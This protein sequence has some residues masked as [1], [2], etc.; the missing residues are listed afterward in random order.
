MCGVSDT[1]PSP[2][3]KE[4]SWGSFPIL[5]VVP[6]HLGPTVVCFYAAGG[7]T[8]PQESILP[9]YSWSEV[10]QPGV[11][12]NVPAVPPLAGRAP[13]ESPGR[14]LDCSS[15]RN[16]GAVRLPLRV[17][18]RVA[19]LRLQERSAEGS[20]LEEEANHVLVALARPLLQDRTQFSDRDLATL[21]K[22]WDNGM[23]SLGS[24]CREKITAVATELNVDCEII[25]ADL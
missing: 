7:G 5:G 6:N 13:V 2:E 3:N 15:R 21:K 14:D 11:L 19:N 9:A 17:Y 22:F 4:G 8:A 23:T 16:H 12:G 10:P 24:V 1:H 25:K 20:A 18:Q